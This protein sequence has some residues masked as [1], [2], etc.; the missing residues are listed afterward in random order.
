MKIKDEIILKDW[1]YAMIIPE[2]LREIIE[3]AVPEEL[4]DRV[5]YVATMAR[6]SGI[7]Q[8]RYIG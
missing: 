1:L 7:G 8:R 3:P 2:E 5:I 4:A 6:I